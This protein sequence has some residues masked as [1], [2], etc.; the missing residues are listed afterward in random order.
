MMTPLRSDVFLIYHVDSKK[1]RLPLEAVFCL[2]QLFKY[3][4]SVAVYED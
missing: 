4:S 1:K 3:T 2:R